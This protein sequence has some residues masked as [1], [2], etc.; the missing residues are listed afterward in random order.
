[1]ATESATRKRER[2]ILSIEDKTEVIDM[3]DHRR[4]LTAIAAKYSVAKSTVSNIK[5]KAE[6]TRVQT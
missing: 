4:S 1:M 6:D 3:L 2:V 5:N